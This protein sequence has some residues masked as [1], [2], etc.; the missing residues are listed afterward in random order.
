MSTAKKI[1]ITPA[2]LKETASQITQN[3]EAYGT[4]FAQLYQHVERMKTEWQ[5]ADNLAYTT[6]IEGFRPHLVA[7]Q[8]LM[9]NYAGYLKSSAELYE[10]TQNEIRTRAGNLVN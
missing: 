2:Q 3:A 9:N 6:Q 1:D 10:Q 4:A 7:L 8:D 5:G